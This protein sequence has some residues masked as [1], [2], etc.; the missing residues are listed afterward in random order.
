MEIKI[1]KEI[2]QYRENVFFGLS[3]R[4]CICSLVAVAIAVGIYFGLKDYVG[5]ET[6]SWLCIVGAA[7]IAFAGFFSYNGML[8][9]RFI[10][11]W[12][13]SEFLCAGKRYFVAENFYQKL[14]ED[15]LNSE[16]KTKRTPRKRERKKAK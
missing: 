14:H 5:Q 7:P 11:V 16:R 13:R 10:V 9:E 8:L 4:Q 6:V 3:L 1:P 15:I 2:R 12:V